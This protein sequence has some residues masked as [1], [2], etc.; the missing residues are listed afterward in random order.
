M[1]TVLSRVAEI[2]ARIETVTAGATPAA[3][4]AATPTSAPTRSSF[5][6]LLADAST[7]GT[8]VVPTSPG[9]Y[10]ELI[11]RAAQR[12]GVDPDLIRAVIKN[13]SGFDPSA[14]SHAGAKGLMQ[15]MPATARGLGVTDPYDP[16]Q[17]IAAGTRMLGRLVERYDGDLSLALAA[18]NAGSGAVAR[19]GGIPPYEETQN[20]VRKV[21]GT[22]AE[23][24]DDPG[25]SSG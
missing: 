12:E 2:S 4:Q 10:D 22:Y 13:E 20:Y 3:T 24:Q 1:S 14:T 5:A 25:R 17:S 16:A 6:N 15:L 8:S 7:T 9:R 11:E 19:Y 23:L 21:L 18:Y